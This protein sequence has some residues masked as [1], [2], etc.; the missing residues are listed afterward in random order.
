MRVLFDLLHPAHVHVF[1][2]AI[3]ELRAQGHEVIVTSRDKDQT[4]YLLDIYGIDHICLS[5]MAGGKL[6]LLWE[7]LLR[8]WRLMRICRRQRP[9]VM[10][11]IMGA[12]IAP[13]GRLM[14]IT[15]HT[16]YDTEMATLTNRYVYRTTDAFIT[17]ECYTAQVPAAIHQTYRGYHELA[18]LHPDRFAPDPAVLQEA[19]LHED[20]RFFVLRFVSWGASHD[21]GHSGLTLEVKRQVVELLAQHGRVIIT[22]EGA[23]PEYFEP[24]RMRVAPEKV[25]HLL[26]YAH[27]LYGESGTMASEAAVLGTHAFFVNNL[28]AGTLQDQQRHGLVFNYRTD[29][30]AVEASLDTLA[31]LAADPDLRALGRAK[32]K[33]MIK[34]MEDLTAFI[35]RKSLSFDKTL[36][37]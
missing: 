21:I 3:T 30:A 7:L 24:Y 16:Y 31:Q 36:Y 28:E 1:R 14:G 8:A 9:D 2:N 6:G 32:A 20:E 11:G 27:L 12:V 34:G 22:S 13:L 17:P 10:V 18:Y 5:R 33:A 35:I 37:R 4:L 15:T 29:A 26:Y 25:H 19:G 23:L